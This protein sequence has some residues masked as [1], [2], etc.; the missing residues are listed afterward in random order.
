[1]SPGR[2]TVG[3]ATHVRGPTLR[4]SRRSCEQPNPNTPEDTAE[5]KAELVS[6]LRSVIDAVVDSCDE[7]ETVSDVVL[8]SATLWI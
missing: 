1:M 2:S 6:T 5:D 3:S 8:N 4:E 7:N